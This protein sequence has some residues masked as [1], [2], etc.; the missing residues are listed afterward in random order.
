MRK[1]ILSIALAGALSAS[2]IAGGAISA[3][4]TRN[5]DGTYTPTKSTT[6]TITY[7]IAMPAAWLNTETDKVGNAPGLYW[8][9]AT[10]SPDDDPAFN[11]HGWP[12]YKC[13]K[14]EEEGVDNL[15][16]IT[17]PKDVTTLVWNN[18]LDG[19]TDKTLPVYL[20][21]TQ[22]KDFAC[23]FYADG[24]SDW[25]SADFWEDVYSHEEDLDFSS[26]GSYA[27][28]F[29]NDEE[30][31]A[32]LV[33]NMNN[34]VF[35]VNLD[36]TSTDVNYEGK[37]TYSGEM[38]FY[39]GGGEYGN[40]PTKELAEAHL[41]DVPEYDTI[42]VTDADGNTV[43]KFHVKNAGSFVRNFTEQ[44]YAPEKQEETPE[45]S[46]AVKKFNPA[47][48]TISFERLDET[49][50][51]KGEQRIKLNLDVQK[52]YEFVRWNIEGDY[53][54][55]QGDET[56]DTEIVITATGDVSVSAT[57]N[58]VQSIATPDDPGEDDKDKDKDKEPASDDP[59]EPSDEPTDDP[60]DDQGE[61]IPAPSDDDAKS[62]IDDSN[63][64]GN[65][66]PGYDNGVIATGET[67]LFFIVFVVV[68]GGCL[69]FYFTR[70]RFDK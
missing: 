38:F 16:K 69:A 44:P 70:K 51:E 20:L 25:Y 13:E 17:V 11:G 1:K 59:T 63:N 46:H 43:N 53:T 58:V 31:G 8:W 35:V 68:A 64:D 52:G 67:V 22:A 36:P 47:G 4:A 42:P 45:G 60:G 2:I 3:S 54:V 19:G 37:P 56:K 21:A 32:G 48:A 66:N 49:M 41:D 50:N 57:V 24:D 39:Y 55:T 65:N 23:E 29:Y 26:Y 33:H 27:S 9:S 6:E 40:W 12:G 61:D 10:D 62:D 28:N 18:Y 7:Y 5:A 34:M 15:Y 14:V 30:Y